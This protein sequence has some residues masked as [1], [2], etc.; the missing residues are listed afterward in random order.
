MKIKLNSVLVRD[1]DHALKF[2]TETLGFE[3][4]IDLPV[5]EFRW[6]T[7]ASPAE[8]DGTQLV[9]EPNANPAAKAYQSA[10]FDAGIPLT[11][12][13]VDDIEHEYR[14]L[15]ALNVAFTAEPAD[16]GGTMI[17]VFDDSC[18]NLIQIYQT[19]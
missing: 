2:Y 18:G 12:F 13:A 15:K 17:A 5:G 14:R 3:K 7:V 6:L 9:L 1:Q 19:P 10:L 8:P 11:A 16:V 4:K